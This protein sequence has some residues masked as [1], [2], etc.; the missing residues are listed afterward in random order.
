MNPIIIEEPFQLNSKLFHFLLIKPGPLSCS[1]L[2]WIGEPC[3]PKLGDLS[4]S[5]AKNSTS[6][7]GDDLHLLSSKLSLKLSNKFSQSKPV[8]VSLN[9]PSTIQT[10][11]FLNQLDQQ[12]V[13]FLEKHLTN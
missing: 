10:G 11:D 3:N 8:Y 9:I 5:V 12:I 1:F 13:S 6:I 7:I 4:L 2:L